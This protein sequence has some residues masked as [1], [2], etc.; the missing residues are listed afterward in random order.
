MAASDTSEAS[1]DLRL[2]T[3]TYRIQLTSQ[4]TFDRAA[5]LAQYL[6]DLG[7][8]ALYCSPVFQAGPGSTHGYDVVDH[9][10]VSIELGG[11]DGWQRM[12]QA[13]A[14]RNMGILLDIV[15]NHMSITQ[16]RNPLWW[17]VLENG[18]L[19]PFACYFDID[20]KTPEP[21]N[22]GKVLIPFLPDQYNNMLNARE[23]LLYRDGGQFTVRACGAWYPLSPESLCDIVARA[24][25]NCSCS[26]LAFLADSLRLLPVE[27]GE[28]YVQDRHRNKQVIFELLAKLMAEDASAAQAIDAVISAINADPEQLDRVLLQQHY[29]LAW[30]RLAGSEINY[31]RFFSIDSLVGLRVELQ[32]VFEHAHKQM[33]Q[34]ARQGELMG[35][36]IDHIDGL[37]APKAYLQRLHDQAGR[38]WTVVEK[39]LQPD[40]TLP[41]AWP[42]DGTTGYDFMNHLGGIFVD[43]SN[44]DAM[45]KLYA[46]FTGESV[47]YAQV[48]RRKKHQVLRESFGGEWTGLT[49]MLKD[50]TLQY[51]PYRDFSRDQLHQ[52]IGE[53]IAVF[54]VYRTYLGPDDTPL[55]AEDSRYIAQ[56]LEAARQ[57]R[58][59]LDGRLWELLADI[60]L[61][62]WRGRAGL[63]FA[64]RFQQITPAVTAKGVEDTTFYAYNRLVSLNEVGSDPSRFGCSVESF[65]Q[66]C[67]FI[68]QHFPGNLSATSTHDT[69]R[70]EDARLR[71]SLLSEIPDAWSAAVHRWRAMN[72]PHRIGDAPSFNHEYLLYQILIGAWPITADRLVGYMIKA[73]REEKARTSWTDVNEQYETVLADFTRGLLTDRAFILDLESFLL[74]LLGRARITSLSQTLIKCTAPGVPDFY[75]GSELWDLSLVDPDNRREVDFDLRQRLLKDVRDASLDEVLA[76]MEEGLP[77]LFVIHRALQLRRRRSE[78]FGPAGE[79]CPI[80][81]DGACR[82]HIVAFMR[83][84]RAITI[85]PRLLARLGDDWKDS[86]IQLPHGQWRDEFSG[87]TLSGRVQIAQVFAKFP[88]ALLAV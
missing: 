78:L 31:R 24:A 55:S 66:Y 23:I 50:I 69:K 13:L 28:E 77:K 37:Y 3:A 42:A 46:Q 83:G 2:P 19:S 81:A 29:R 44:E 54:P 11:P 62:R 7:V 38:M 5:D 86:S 39:I 72:A 71:I 34:W 63:D 59:E 58:P 18:P 21:S 6:E 40:E 36:R 65:H 80:A 10:H 56:A 87:Q 12:Q 85:A 26:M 41:Q 16:G 45:T 53:L 57:N 20:W 15:P 51:R 32:P 67:Q 70:G 14:R 27:P 68:Q 9:Q 60:L 30:W 61:R 75:Q 48:V 74:P 17:D 84:G 88:V 64:L 79:Y 8:G 25:G 73:A 1:S 49:A 47:D 82:E 52:A 35:V 43:P 4:F 76:R 33:L 22:R